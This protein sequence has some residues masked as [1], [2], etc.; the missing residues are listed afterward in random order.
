MFFI[1]QFL[2]KVIH[3]KSNFDIKNMI[4]NSYYT[5]ILLIV[6]NVICYLLLLENY[7]RKLKRIPKFFSIFYSIFKNTARDYFASKFIKVI[8]LEDQNLIIY[9][10]FH[11]GQW[12]TI[13]KI[14]DDDLKMK[15]LNVQILLD[16]S[17]KIYDIT[18]PNGHKY[19]L[20]SDNMG[21][22]IQVIDIF[23]VK[24]TL[25]DN[26]SLDEFIISLN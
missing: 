15:S 6:L 16:V 5:I 21:D 24:K 11:D 2:P 10:I 3:P 23:N 7:R 1:D 13:V 14:N 22:K 9:K 26:K 25:S 8:E 20:K 12:K 18:Q 17:E 4:L 19:H